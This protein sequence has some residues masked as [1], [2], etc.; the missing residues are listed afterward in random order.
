MILLNFGCQIYNPAIPF[1][2]L[3]RKRLHVGVGVVVVELLTG[4]LLLGK[5]S[6]QIVVR[7]AGLRLLLGLLPLAAGSSKDGGD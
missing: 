7:A 5:N 2:L 4:D 6:I 1:L 3:H